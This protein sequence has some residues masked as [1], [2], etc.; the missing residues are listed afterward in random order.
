[1]SR[2]AR[3]NAPP[4]QDLGDDLPGIMLKTTRPNGLCKEFR[5]TGNPD[6]EHSGLVVK[7]SR[8]LWVTGPGE[9]D[10]WIGLDSSSSGKGYT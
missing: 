4:L 10:A 8:R 1:M 5:G 9:D 7:R 3:S 2:D 6:E